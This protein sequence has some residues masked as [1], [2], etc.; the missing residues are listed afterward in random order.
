MPKIKIHPWVR[1][2]GLVL[3]G[4]AVLELRKNIVLK[5]I[6]IAFLHHVGRLILIV[7]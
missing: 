6:K 1:V 4:L 2:F 7:L 5:L 3:R